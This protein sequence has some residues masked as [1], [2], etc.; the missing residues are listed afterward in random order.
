[1]EFIAASP[2]FQ[3]LQAEE[4][5]EMAALASVRKYAAGE[6]IFDESDKALGFHLVTEG[7]VKVFKSAP[8]GKERILHLFGPGEPFGEAAIF[9]GRGY[10]AS[11][12]A[13]SGATTLFFPREELKR[14]I[15]ENPD[16]ALA[17]MAVMAA[18]LRRFTDMLEA[19]AL[20]EL[21]ARLAAFILNLAP[22]G[23]VRAE[24]TLSKGQLAS[25]LG[26]APESLSR[27]MTGLKKAGLIAEEKHFINILDR[28]RLARLAS[29]D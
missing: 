3:G 27:A 11:A 10:P 24:L 7:R 29:G 21:P 12:L 5:R 4:L 14:R 9:A 25:L 2:F 16:L 17:L 1:M 20:K 19:A 18:R 8:D 6:L 23:E 26:S 13:V 28:S 22:G 15:A